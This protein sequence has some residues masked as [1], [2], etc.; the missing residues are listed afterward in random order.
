MHNLF[1]A[2]LALF[3]VGAFLRMDWVYYLV[4]VLGGVWIFSHV[5]MRT[6]LGRIDVKR[7]LPE[8]AFAGETLHA[9]LQIT[10]HSLLPLPW[11]QVQEVVPLDLKDVTDY[12]TVVS[13]GS[14]A[15]L[16]HTYQLYCRRRG[17]FSVGPISLHSS[18]VF[19]FVEARWDE[20]TPFRLIVYPQVVALEKLGIPSR[21]LYGTLS[22]R[23]RLSDDPARM[24]GVRAYATGD[25]LRRV[26]WKATAHE[27]ALLVKKF[28][29]SKA[30]PVTLVLDLNRE[31]YPTRTMVGSSEWGIV[32]AASVASHLIAQ[33]QPVGLVTNGLDALTGNAAGPLPQR[34]GQEQ[35]MSILSLLARVQLRSCPQPLAEWLPEQLATVSWGTT[36][37]L[38]T[39]TFDEA[40]LWTLHSAR[41]RGSD[42][43]VLVC[44]RQSDFRHMQAHAARL[45]VG[46]YSTIWESDLKGLTA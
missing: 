1:W 16:E 23:H 14:R 26:H 15:S 17:Y 18:D 21:A 34:T 30:V 46:V 22:T 37:I 7:I 45:G 2:L 31:A 5:W 13:L 38:I 11:L 27:E 25:S 32:V 33:R 6:T 9:R 42:I 20:V 39:P 8:R 35:L 3:L 44:D 28:D 29:P 43:Q 19:G 40:T 36:L 10:N 24:A 4:Y 12:R 41:R